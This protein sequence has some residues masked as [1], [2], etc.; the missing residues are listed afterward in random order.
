M[1]ALCA[2]FSR[3]AGL[4]LKTFAAATAARLQPPRLLARAMTYFEHISVAASPCGR[5]VAVCDEVSAVVLWRVQ[6]GPR[7]PQQQ[8]QQH[9]GCDDSADQLLPW[10]L[11]HKATLLLQPPDD[12]DWGVNAVRFGLFAGR[13]RLLVAHQVRSHTHT[14]T[15]TGSVVCVC[16]RLGWGRM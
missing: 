16:G 15:H 6:R 10:R 1:R 5:F 13:M 14:H 2:A 12:R 11:E 3:P 7:V 8:Q 9:Q 4:L